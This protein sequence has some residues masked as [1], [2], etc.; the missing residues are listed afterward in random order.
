MRRALTVVA[1]TLVA[2]V[3]GGGVASAVTDPA[4]DVARCPGLEGRLDA[5]PDLVDALG[6]VVELGTSIRW[7]L[8]F[9]E[10]LTVPD[11][12]G[13]PF[14]VEIVL[15][16][17]KVP[18]VSFAFYRRVNRLLRYDAVADPVL[19][20]LLL[21]E[22]GQSRFT[23]P[24]VD[25]RTLT[26]RIPGR[27]LTAD[28]DE[29]GTSPG[30][31]HLRWGVVVRDGAACDLL[32]DGRPTEPLVIVEGAP[33]PPPVTAADADGG[34]TRWALLCAA[35]VVVAAIAVAVYRWRQTSS[36]RRR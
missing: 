22:R 20:T 14:R 34:W 5:A 33:T 21:P 32:G 9:E 3:A 12:E 19:T 36:T 13:T 28:E 6:E 11:T 1:A 26:I 25:G 30:L 18:I 7:T 29:T 24:V 23:A 17:P 31:D 10:P 4:G 15:F 8:T 27:A 35:I 16:D 2:V